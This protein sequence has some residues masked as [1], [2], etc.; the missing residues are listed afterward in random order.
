[1]KWHRPPLRRPCLHRWPPPPPLPSP[2]WWAATTTTTSRPHPLRPRRI[3]TTTTR[4]QPPQQP[5]RP[6]LKTPL[7]SPGSRPTWPPPPQPSR[8]PPDLAPLLHPPEKMTPFWGLLEERLGEYIY[9][10]ILILDSGY[11]VDFSLSRRFGNIL[12]DVFM[13]PPNRCLFGFIANLITGI[14]YL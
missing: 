4:P 14:Q 5:P 8:S 6:T 3:T 11:I 7:S 2:E 10:F 13:P 12:S 9:K 1:M